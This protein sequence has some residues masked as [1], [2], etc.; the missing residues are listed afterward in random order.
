MNAVA[1]VDHSHHHQTVDD[2]AR[3]PACGG[4]AFFIPTAERW[5]CGND[6]FPTGG[7]SPVWMAGREACPYP[8]LHES[9]VQ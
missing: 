4:R 1:M 3:C 5:H 7:L 8:H 9:V 2:Y 6:C